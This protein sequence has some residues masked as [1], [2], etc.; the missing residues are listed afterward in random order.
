MSLYA[1]V[2]WWIVIGF[3]VLQVVLHLMFVHDRMVAGASAYAISAVDRALALKQLVAGI[4]VGERSQLFA[5]ASGPEFRVEIREQ[6]LSPGEPWRHA[7]EIERAIA[8]HLQAKEGAPRVATAVFVTG[9]G[10]G[11]S[12]PALQ[13]STA[14]DDGSYLVATATHLSG[15]EDGRPVFQAA[16]LTAFVVVLVLWGA[17]RS[18]RHVPRFA[19]AAEALGRNTA[20]AP[21]PEQGP[22]E[23]RKAAIAF[24]EMA[25]RIRTHLAERT[26]ILAAVSHDVRTALTKLALRIE[27]ADDPAQRERARED[28]A[29]MTALLDDL[30]VL[31]REERAEEE[32][33]RL[34]VATLVQALVDDDASLG[35]IASYHGDDHVV[36]DGRPR[37]LRRALTNLLDNAHRY[38]GS[39][40]AAVTA[41]GDRAV[42]EISDRGPGIP[43]TERARVVK[44]FERLERS[45]NQDTGGSG[46]GLAIVQAVVANHGGTLELLERMGG[47][48]TVRVSLPR[49]AAPTT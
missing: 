10:R 40:E 23:V 39:V 31:V 22:R 29:Q 7:D 30:V 1:R 32:R 27:R 9:S 15:D 44:P 41:S 34:D 6:P 21:L 36:I 37:A 45:R 11:L 13:I 24:N 43:S 47:G 19:A 2:A 28:I 38:A 12:A 3:V 42:I 35:R 48:L 20:A 26:Q 5:A 18:M 8:A 46:L 16:A 4:A 25:E 14:L 49:G 17:R 33:Q